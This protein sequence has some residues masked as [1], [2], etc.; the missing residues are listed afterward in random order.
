MFRNVFAAFFEE[1]MDFSPI[2]LTSLAVTETFPF[3]TNLSSPGL[4]R[5]AGYY[6]LVS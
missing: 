4:G 2:F 5:Y 1:I 6:L 3:L